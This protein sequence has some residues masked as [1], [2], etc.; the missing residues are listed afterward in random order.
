[1]ETKVWYNIENTK[2]LFLEDNPEYGFLIIEVD[3][4]NSFEHFGYIK[5]T[6]ETFNSL[7]EWKDMWS[8]EEASLRFKQG[9]KLFLLRDNEGALGHV[10]FANFYLYNLFIHPRREQGL[11]EK[12]IKYCISKIDEPEIFC[13]CDSWNIRA[14]KFFEKVGFM[15]INS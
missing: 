10:W 13:Y 7:I 6:V 11:S 12:F 9:D 1:M 2:K 5:N 3:D 8:M 15:K 4:S 14:Q